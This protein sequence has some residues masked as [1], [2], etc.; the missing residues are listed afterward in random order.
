M[1]VY[2]CTCVKTQ[3]VVRDAFLQ[4]L[5]FYNP[6]NNPEQSPLNH[7]NFF[8]SKIA[9]RKIDKCNFPFFLDFMSSREFPVSFEIIELVTALFRS[10]EVSNN[11]IERAGQ[12]DNSFEFSSLKKKKG[13]GS[14]KRNFVSN[15]RR[16]RSKFRTFDAS[17]CAWSRP[18]AMKL[19][20]KTRPAAIKLENDDRVRFQF[21]VLFI[22]LS[23]WTFG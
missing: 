21:P 11:A 8:C 14:R 23:N 18:S 7:L 17:N 19:I 9:E 12:R 15:A 3:L 16:F 10:I 13:R 1:C 2:V 22:I 5:T 6:G 4:H 20:K